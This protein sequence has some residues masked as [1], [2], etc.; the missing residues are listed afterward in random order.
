M[1]L[2]N[3]VRVV[4]SSNPP[5]GVV[6]ALSCLFHRL[7]GHGAQVFGQRLDRRRAL[8]GH[9]AGHVHEALDTI[10][11][12]AGDLRDREAA[13]RVTDEHEPFEAGGVDVAQHRVGKIRDRQG[14]QLG[15]GL[16]TSRP[17]AHRL[18]REV[19]GERVAVE[20]RQQSLPAP[21]AVGAAMHEHEWCRQCVRRSSR[22]L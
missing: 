20:E 13:H 7:A 4:C 15:D 16:E 19:D 10:G 6:A 22:R 21:G 11:H 17:A 5:I 9:H 18:G 2:Q 8:R 3:I 1:S 12:A 14:E